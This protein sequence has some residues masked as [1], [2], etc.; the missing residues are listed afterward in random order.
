MIRTGSIR[1]FGATRARLFFH[2]PVLCFKHDLRTVDHRPLAE[3]AAAGP[4]LPLY[5]TEP[6]YWRL[7]KH[8]ITAMDRSALGA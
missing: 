1:P 7:S 8:L 2:D 3:A 4:V 6:D 5:V